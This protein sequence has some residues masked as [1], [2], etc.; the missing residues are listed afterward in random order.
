VPFY[1]TIKQGEPVDQRIADTEIFYKQAVAYMN[2]LF[3]PLGLRRYVPPPNVDQT[4]TDRFG[5]PAVTD[6]S[7]ADNLLLFVTSPQN[8]YKNDQITFYLNMFPD[9]LEV[10]QHGRIVSVRLPGNAHA[11]VRLV[12]NALTQTVAGIARS[13]LKLPAFLANNVSVQQVYPSL[14]EMQQQLNRGGGDYIMTAY[15]YEDIYPHVGGLPIVV[16]LTQVK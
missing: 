15:A 14:A 10:P 2:G 9:R 8:L 13:E 6:A 11:N 7:L 1:K 16:T 3:V 12:I 5:G 4:L